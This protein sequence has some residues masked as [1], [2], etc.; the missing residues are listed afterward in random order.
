MIVECSTLEYVRVTC[1]DMYVCQ[2]VYK[3]VVQYLLMLNLSF[4][5]LILASTFLFKASAASVAI[6]RHLNMS[7][8]VNVI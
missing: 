8:E 7:I 2:V 1:V 3:D 4:V 6:S 5:G